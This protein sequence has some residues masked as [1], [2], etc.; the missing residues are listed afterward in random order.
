MTPAPAQDRAAWL[1]ARRS[2]LG[3]SDMAAVLGI[4]GS[5]VEVW[6]SKVFPPG[7][8]E[9][10]TTDRMRWGKRLEQAIVQEYAA[11]TGHDVETFGERILRHPEVAWWIGTPDAAVR[12]PVKDPQMPYTRGVEAKNTGHDQR[13]RWGPSGTD[14]APEGYVV[15]CCHYMPLLGKRGV[16]VFDLYA[17]IGGNEDRVYTILRDPK[18][19]A[20]LLEEGERFWT[21]HVLAK[22]P[23]PMDGSSAAAWYVQKRFPKNVVDVRDATEAERALLIRLRDARSGFDQAEDT[24]DAVE[25]E[26]KLAI[27][28]SAG[29]R[30]AEGVATWK[31]SKARRKTDWPAVLGEI[32]A[33][34]PEQRAAIEAAVNKHTAEEP[35]SRRFL[36]SPSATRGV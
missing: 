23:P 20:V 18:L 25:N 31:G 26:I 28:E 16:D 22:V 29:L 24:R 3:G 8:G 13:W 32:L 4:H 33:A 7:D 30:C 2:G 6:A 17:L 27:G 14:E 36:W 12:N 35:G 5:R 21:K 1:E 11:L 9:R 15:Q 19:E 10:A 34:H